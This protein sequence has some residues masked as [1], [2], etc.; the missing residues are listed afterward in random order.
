M[1]RLVIICVLMLA[2]CGREAETVYVSPDVPAGLLEPCGGYRGPSP[3]TQGQLI[4]AAFLE[5]SGRICAN[6]K[7]ASVKQILGDGR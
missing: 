5:R 6:N 1:S 7:L 3:Q 4:E 2:A